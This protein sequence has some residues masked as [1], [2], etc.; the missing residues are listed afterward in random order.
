MSGASFSLALLL[1]GAS[2]LSGQDTYRIG[3]TFGGTSSIG[4]SFEM[5]WGDAAVDL[6]LGT[7][8]FR[9]ISASV[10]GKYYAGAESFKGYGGLGLWFI[11][12]FPKEEDERTGFATVLRIPVGMEGIIDHEH[13]LG[14]E[15]NLDRALSVRRPDPTDDLPPSERFIPLPGVYYKYG[16]REDPN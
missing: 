14:L 15:V 12:A 7:W 1:L 11:T 5:L 10:V 9:D 8:G 6:S 4:L 3:V 16:N 2:S 13:A